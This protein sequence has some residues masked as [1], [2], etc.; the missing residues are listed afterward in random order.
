[1]IYKMDNWEISHFCETFQLPKEV[2]SCQDSVYYQKQ[3]CS[4]NL[5][6]AV[7][8]ILQSQ[9]KRVN[10]CLIGYINI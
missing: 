9:L 2:I 6:L 10:N 4:S 3:Y 8:T 5:Q 7:I 1:M